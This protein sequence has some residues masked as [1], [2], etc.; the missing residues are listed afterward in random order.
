MRAAW[1]K[2]KQVQKAAKTVRK[3]AIKN[4][5]AKYKADTK[6]CPDINK[7]TSESSITDNGL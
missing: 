4:A 6:T 2:F 7:T 3:T 1:T 5:W